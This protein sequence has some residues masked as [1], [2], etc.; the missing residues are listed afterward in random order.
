MIIIPLLSK[1]LDIIK[2]SNR[3]T[4]TIKAKIKFAW[5]YLPPEFIL[6]NNLKSIY[7]GNIIKTSYK[8]YSSR[9]L[10]G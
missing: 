3:N 2:F 5:V 4:T 7:T 6:Y 8:F 1:H 9:R 10:L